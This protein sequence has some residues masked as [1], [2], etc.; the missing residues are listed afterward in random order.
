MGDHKA[1]GTEPIVAM[2]TQPLV[3][4]AKAADTAKREMSEAEAK[5]PQLGERW[6]TRKKQEEEEEEKEGRTE[7]VSNLLFTTTEKEPNEK[8][9]EVS[10]SAGQ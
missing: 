10:L 4:P 5:E 1:D 8:F 2:E 7:F 9:S 3:E 6:K